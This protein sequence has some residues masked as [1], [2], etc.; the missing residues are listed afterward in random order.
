MTWT[1]CAQDSALDTLAAARAAVLPDLQ[2]A[3]GAGPG[4]AQPAAELQSADPLQQAR[5]L[6]RPPRAASSAPVL[7]RLTGGA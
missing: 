3:A 6:V 5:M 4:C 1:P 2:Q 7:A